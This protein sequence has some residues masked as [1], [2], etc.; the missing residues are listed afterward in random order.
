[1]RSM[2]A[3]PGSAIRQKVRVKM[4]NYTTAKPGYKFILTGKGKEN[5]KIS[6]KFNQ[7]YQHKGQYQYTVP[8][9]WIK[10]GYVV[11]VPV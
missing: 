3:A 9:K 11:E 1:M 6:Y 2:D 7:G 4:C 10:E 5:P 8:E